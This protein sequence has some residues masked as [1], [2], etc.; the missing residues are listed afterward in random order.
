MYEI[1]IIQSQ[2]TDFGVDYE[3]FTM[4]FFLLIDVDIFISFQVCI[5]I[6]KRDQS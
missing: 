6:V 4:N 5:S 1:S 3:F 2:D